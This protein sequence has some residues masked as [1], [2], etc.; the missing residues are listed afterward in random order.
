MLSW[1][2]N[3]PRSSRWIKTLDS[4]SSS[5]KE[6]SQLLMEHP[7]LLQLLDSQ[8]NQAKRHSPLILTSTISIREQQ[9]KRLKV[10]MH[11]IS[12]TSTKMIHPSQ[13][14]LEISLKIQQM[15]LKIFSQISQLKAKTKKEQ[16]EVWET[17]SMISSLVQASL[18]LLCN[19]LPKPKETSS[20]SFRASTTTQVVKALP[21]CSQTRCQC[22]TSCRISSRQMQIL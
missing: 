22:K 16:L 4:L 9:I 14:E 7:P 19:Q 21:Q 5:R 17:P 13:V 12:S 1:L 18:S 3:Q 10:K 15:S 8:P 2:R 11:L 20:K 6:I